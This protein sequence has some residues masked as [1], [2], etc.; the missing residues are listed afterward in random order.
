MHHT[1]I[2]TTSTSTAASFV[3]G[4]VIRVL[5]ANRDAA[6]A[7]FPP[8]LFMM[9]VLLSL[10]VTFITTLILASKSH[11]ATTSRFLLLDQL[12]QIFALRLSTASLA[13]CF[14]P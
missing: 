10:T 5:Y 6:E 1:L 12:I 9:A 4:P 8:S 7:T 2:V 11:H 14:N 13:S 3:A